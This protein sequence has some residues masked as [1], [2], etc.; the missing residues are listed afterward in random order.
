MSKLN[1]CLVFKYIVYKLFMPLQATSDET[2]QNTSPQLEHTNGRKSVKRG[3]YL[4]QS[5]LSSHK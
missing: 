3:Q 5:S 4:M 1:S 2:Y